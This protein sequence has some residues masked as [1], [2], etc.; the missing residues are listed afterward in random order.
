MYLYMGVQAKILLNIRGPGV[1]VNGSRDAVTLDCEFYTENLKDLSIKWYYMND[2]IKKPQLMYK[3][4]PPDKPQTFSI[5]ENKLDLSY[6]VSNN[7]FTKHRA[8]RILKPVPEMSGRYVCYVSNSES[9]ETIIH[10]LTIFEPEKNF[11]LFFHR[12]EDGYLNIICLAKGIYPK[13]QIK[14]LADNT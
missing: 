12:S 10:S 2:I 9:D 14:L 8:L 1:F 5:F 6:T 11:D 7:S 4:K 13:P 3:W